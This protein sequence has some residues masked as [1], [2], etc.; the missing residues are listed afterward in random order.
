VTVL[1]CNPG[2]VGFNGRMGGAWGEG[3][4]SRRRVSMSFPCDDLSTERGWGDRLASTSNTTQEFPSKLV[5]ST[6]QRFVG[7]MGGLL[8]RKKQ[9]EENYKTF[10][11]REES[12]KNQRRSF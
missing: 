8:H 9:K 12:R 7:G 5:C 3:T 4:R 1:H 11:I 2:K 6:C 10:L